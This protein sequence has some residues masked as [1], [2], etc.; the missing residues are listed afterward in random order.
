MIKQP[1]FL[2]AEVISGD[3]V[4]AATGS[5]GFVAKYNSDRTRK[6]VRF[7]Y[8]RTFAEHYFLDNKYNSFDIDVNAEF[9]P[10][11]IVNVG[12]KRFICRDVPYPCYDYLNVVQRTAR[13]TVEFGNELIS[14]NR[15]R[16]VT[17]S[18][19]TV[20][21]GIDEADINSDILDYGIFSR[22]D[23]SVISLE[24]GTIAS[25]IKNNSYETY[26]FNGINTGFLKLKLSVSH[27]S[28]VIAAFDEIGIDGDVDTRRMRNMQQSV[29]WE[30]K[31]GEY[32][33]VS[34][35]PYVMQYLKLILKSNNN[36]AVLKVDTV[37][38]I[39]FVFN[40]KAK[41]LNS[42]DGVIDKIY[43]AAVE[44]FKQNVL[45][46]YMDCASRERAGWLCDSFFTART[47]YALTGKSVVE[48]SFLE[49]FVIS[50]GFQYIEKGMLPMCYPSDFLTGEYIPNWAMWYVL[51]LS[52]Y[53]DR[54]G[55]RE[56]IEEAKE[57][58]FSL[59]KFFEQFENEDGLL[60]KLRGWVFLEWSAANGFVQ[61]VNYPSNMLYAKMLKEVGKL[62]G[63]NYS[64]KANKIFDAV[65]KQSYFDGFYHDHA[66]RNKDGV[67]EV[68]NN[69]ISETCQYYAFHTGCTDIETNEE[70]WEKMLEQFGPDRKEG[71]YSNVHPS[72]A[73]IGYYLRLDN[74]SNEIEKRK[75]TGLDTVHL[76]EKLISDI[77]GFFEYMAD[78]TGTLWENK[79]AG[80]SC[81][82]GFASHVVVWLHKLFK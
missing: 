55:D 53:F 3:E 39:N 23:S 74:I 15:D 63:G 43:M 65:N 51:E 10:V 36:Q 54:T 28:T 64:E 76:E 82:H 16:F 79:D 22:T 44:T 69:D 46:V 12:E 61:D 32:T 31:A 1:S 19:D 29:I 45:D 30:L 14:P 62:Y 13:G 20:G 11:S 75:K 58:V 71:A 60:E 80:G 70:L 25:E 52:E 8:Q 73:F 47:E 2:C 7:S 18:E 9:T 40:Y 24:N 21:F 81:S 27:D 68:V 78:T 49:N 34:N 4:I 67:L 59:V 48:K 41:P 50:D 5:N 6:V 38:I 37:G 57:R 33:L 66:V 26:R 42:G 17:L 35:E 72:N 56:F 77:K